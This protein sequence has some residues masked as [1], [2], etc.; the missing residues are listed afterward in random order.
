MADSPRRFRFSL[1]TLIVAVNA[2]GALMWVNMN[3]QHCKLAHDDA[4]IEKWRKGWPLVYHENWIFYGEGYTGELEA[5]PGGTVI[6]ALGGQSPLN[7]KSVLFDVSVG[8]AL[9][10]LSAVLTEFLVRR[11]RKAKRHDG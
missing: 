5:T 10:A 7:I 6:G 4:W 3:T 2:A 9:V 1:I 11:I 8:V